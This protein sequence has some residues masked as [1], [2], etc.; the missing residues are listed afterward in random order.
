[1]SERGKHKTPRYEVRDV[2]VADILIDNKFENSRLDRSPSDDPNG[3]AAYTQS[4]KN[5]AED[6]REHGL[7]HPLTARERPDEGLDDS[8]APVEHT[9]YL[10]RAGFRRFGAILLLGWEEVQASIIP[11]DAP[12]ELDYWINIQENLERED[13]SPYEIAEAALRMQRLF[14]R[15]GS[16]FARESKRSAS[17]VNN[18]IRWRRLLPQPIIDDWRR[19]HPLLTQDKIEKLSHLNEDEA[20]AAWEAEKG[21]ST[22]AVLAGPHPRGLQPE[23]KGLPRSPRR[24]KMNRLIA[25]HGAIEISE[26]IQDPKT[27]ELALQLVRFC[28]GSLKTIPG[29]YP[30][31]RRKKKESDDTAST[32]TTKESTDGHQQPEPDSP[33]HTLSGGVDDS[34]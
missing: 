18:L 31:V 16:D 2:L 25:L 20:I 8:G 11:A 6:I 10:M 22:I 17:Y 12:L 9:S 33:A 32:T 28:Q 15:S 21:S 23:N 4:L 3:T 13:L 24:P 27:R 30:P 7:F 26:V 29:I 1:M 5:L 14:D 19:R 34:E